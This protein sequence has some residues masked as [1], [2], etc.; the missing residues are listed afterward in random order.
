MAHAVLI[1]ATGTDTDD[2][3]AR[4]RAAAL[5]LEQ[6]HEPGVISGAGWWVDIHETVPEP[7]LLSGDIGPQE[8][9]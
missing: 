2:L 4:V 7:C 3:A 1:F 6:H 9:H 5:E 8:E